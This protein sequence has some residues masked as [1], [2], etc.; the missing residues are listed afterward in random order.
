MVRHLTDR[1]L[2]NQRLQRFFRKSMQALP[3]FALV[4]L[5]SSCALSPK[6]YESEPVEVQTPSGIVT[7]QLYTSDLVVWDRAI[8]RPES[9]SVTAA[10]DICIEEG[11]RRAEP[12][13]FTGLFGG[14]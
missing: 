4:L 14:G 12:S 9:M 2:E 7:C 1:D 3:A 10:D 5:T 13:I 6:D 11:E 8:Q